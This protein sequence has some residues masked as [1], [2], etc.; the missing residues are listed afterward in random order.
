[1]EREPA[2]HLNFHASAAFCQKSRRFVGIPYTML[3]SPRRSCRNQKQLGACIRFGISVLRQKHPSI[4]RSAFSAGTLVAD[5]LPNLSLSQ[6]GNKSRTMKNTVLNRVLSVAALA[7]VATGSAFAGTIYF[8]ENFN[9]GLSPTVWG[10]GNGGTGNGYVVGGALTFHNPASAGDTQTINA[11]VPASANPIYISF[12][13][14]GAGGYL[15]I[16]PGGNDWLAGQSGYVGNFGPVVALNDASDTPVS[17]WQ[18]FQVVLPSLGTA[19]KLTMEDF[20]GSPNHGAF[21]DNIIVSDYPVTSTAD[22][23]STLGLLGFGAAVLF[24]AR[25]K[26]AK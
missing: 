6:S 14:K 20:W 1:M 8:S 3:R 12:D 11:V 21:F 22:S 17:S 23:G 7:S 10:P 4:H 9:S 25:R 2:H 26:F 18:H 16:N 19:A 5:K 24:A 15:G 13:Y